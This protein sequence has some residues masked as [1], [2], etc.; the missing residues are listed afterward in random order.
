MRK[1]KQ[2]SNHRDQTAACGANPHL[3]EQQQGGSGGDQTPRVSEPYTPTWQEMKLWATARYQAFV[4]DTL[5]ASSLGRASEGEDDGS[6]KII[7]PASAGAAAA[8]CAPTASC[9][10]HAA[11]AGHQPMPLVLSGQEQ[12]VLRWGRNAAV[13]IPRHLPAMV[14]KKATA[15]EV[16]VAYLYLTAPSRCAALVAAAVRLR[17]PEELRA[18]AAAEAGRAGA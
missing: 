17:P 16:L 18:A 8:S 13:N 9:A 11:A 6:A 3:G 12:D 4:Y 15:V 7:D 2:G 5:V 14:Y 1:G 10:N